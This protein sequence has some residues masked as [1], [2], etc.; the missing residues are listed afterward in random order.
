[1]YAVVL[2]ATRE[3]ACRNVDV[4]H[5]FVLGRIAQA[6]ATLAPEVSVSGTSDLTLPGPSG[7]ASRK[8]F[9]G[10]SLRL[11]RNHLLYH[12]TL[13]YDFPLA[14]LNHWLD[15]PARQPKY[16]DQRDHESFVTN[17]SATRQQLTAA[18][19]TSWN[20]SKPLTDWPRQRTT[21]LVASRYN[22]PN[23]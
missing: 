21:N 5:R 2:D 17:L 7:A 18:L 10:N 11:K 13:L 1:M 23:W 14:K 4:A 16:R 3:A 12:G 15:R 6:I 19:I 9:S 22:S 20:A 8:K